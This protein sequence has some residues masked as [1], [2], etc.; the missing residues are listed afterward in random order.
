MTA[1]DGAFS[2]AKAKGR[3]V[4]CRNEAE[5]YRGLLRDCETAVEESQ[6]EQDQIAAMGCALIA[7][8]HV[9][10]YEAMALAYERVSRGESPFGQKP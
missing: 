8:R 2:R 5:W 1:L 7:R 10:H 4:G 9:E 6:D 3:A